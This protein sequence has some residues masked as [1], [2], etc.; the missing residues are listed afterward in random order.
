MIKTLT[1]ALVH[2]TVAFSVAYLLTGSV[3]VGGLLALVEP[4]LNTVAYHLHE[5]AW[6]RIEAMRRGV[7]AAPRAIATANP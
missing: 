4:T 6:R 3:V 5:R 1:F 2:F 7:R